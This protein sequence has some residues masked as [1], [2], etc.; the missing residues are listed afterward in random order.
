MDFEIISDKDR[1]LI[2][3]LYLYQTH[4]LLG[5]LKYRAFNEKRSP[6]MEDVSTEDLFNYVFIHRKHLIL[7]V[8]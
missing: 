7:S 4:E 8:K 5:E 6:N 2:Q 1:E 3:R